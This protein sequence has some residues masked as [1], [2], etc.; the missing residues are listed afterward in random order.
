MSNNISIHHPSQKSEKLS[1]NVWRWAFMRTPFCSIALGYLIAANAWG[2]EVTMSTKAEEGV[3]PFIAGETNL[4]DG[5]ALKVYV[6]LF[7]EVGGVPIAEEVVSVHSGKFKAGPFLQNG[8]PLDPGKYTLE[9]GAT[10]GSHQHQSVIRITGPNGENL[11]GPLVQ[12]VPAPS[13]M[14]SENIIEYTTSFKVGNIKSSKKGDQTAITLSDIKRIHHEVIRYAKKYGETELEFAQR[15]DSTPENIEA[16]VWTAEEGG[17]TAKDILKSLEGLSAALKNPNN[18]SS[19][20]PQIEIPR[21]DAQGFCSQSSYQPTINVCVQK[22]Q[23]Y[24]DYIKSMWPN[25]SDSEKSLCITRM[26]EI[27]SQNQVR[28]HLPSGPPDGYLYE[29]LAGCVQDTLDADS[30]RNQPPFHY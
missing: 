17:A 24:Y 4:P 1:V 15:I 21:Y 29:P 6:H 8:E 5:S 10:F 11:E 28:S 20:S 2:L 26:Q 14:K 12:K 19:A 3:N 13:G 18:D 23:N 25:L 16:I 22:F 27:K 7:G 30:I 9:I